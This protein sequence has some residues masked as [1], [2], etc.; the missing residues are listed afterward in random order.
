LLPLTKKFAGYGAILWTLTSIALHLS[1]RQKVQPSVGRLLALECARKALA[2]EEKPACGCAVPIN[3]ASPRGI[4]KR[5]RAPENKAQEDQAEHLTKSRRLAQ[6]RPIDVV[7]HAAG[8][9]LTCTAPHP[10]AV[11]LL[12]QPAQPYVSKKAQK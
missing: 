9:S 8:P 5:Q 11:L 6:S 1:V 3:G 7:E 12:G 10:Y 2:Y 4:S